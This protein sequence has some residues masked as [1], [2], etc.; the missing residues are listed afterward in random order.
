MDAAESVA[1]VTGA[2]GGDGGAIERLVRVLTPVIHSRVARTLLCGGRRGGNLREDVEDLSQD[3]FLALFANEERVLRRWQ[4][5]RG[6]SLENFVGL[7][8]ERLTYSYRRSGRRNA[9]KEEPTPGEDLDLPLDE[10]GAEQI[11]ID[12]EHLAL[13]LERLSG[14]LS[15]LGWWMFVLLFMKELSTEEVMAVTGLSRDAVDAWRS[16]LRRLARK[17]RDELSGIEG[18]QRRPGKED[19]G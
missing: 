6:L 19:R 5:E 9:W 4:P 11:A 18:A 3:V 12:K 15:E 16:R 1:L 13:L 10:P 8:A 14:E 7:I 2:L 17:L